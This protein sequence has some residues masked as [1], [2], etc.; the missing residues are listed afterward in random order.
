[1]LKLSKDMN[2]QNGMAFSYTFFWYIER[3]YGN[4]G[5]SRSAIKKA[6]KSLKLSS[7]FDEYIHNVCYY[8]FAMDQWLVE[9]SNYAT[10]N[11]EKCFNYFL[12]N[13]FHKNTMQILGILVIIYQRMQNK[14]KVIKISKRIMSSELFINKNQE[15]IRFIGYYFAG[16]GQ[17]LVHNI[18]L[19]EKLFKE[20]YYIINRK[21]EQ[22]SYY[23]YYYIRL[24]AHLATIKALQG[25]TGESSELMRTIKGLL[26][27][28][29]VMTGK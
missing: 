6:M 7:E 28:R 23:S 8:C 3:Y 18:E 27:I 26:P 1:M 2:Y 29:V 9:H 15:D 21:L 24:L 16:V 14:R 10:K 22:S 13:G 20:S 19:A 4:I 5:K 17:L 25:K 12:V 11:F